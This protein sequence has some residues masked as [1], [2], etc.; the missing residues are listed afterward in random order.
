MQEIWKVIEG[1]EDYQISNFGKVKSKR[2]GKERLLKPSKTSWGYEGIKIYNENG[3]KVTMVHREVAKA[4][5]DNPEN[6]PTVNHKDGVKDNNHVDNLEWMTMKEQM[7]HAS[8]TNLMD[9]RVSS[10]RVDM[11]DMNMNY[12]RSFNSTNEAAKFM[13]FTQPRVSECCIGIR[14]K[15]YKG[16]IFKFNQI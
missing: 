2:R 5:I 3:F 9:E 16:Y 1:F 7:D 15:F 10:K 13:G 14:R 8:G 4:F 12:I 11:F 6:K